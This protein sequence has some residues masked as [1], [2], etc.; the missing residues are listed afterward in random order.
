MGLLLDSGQRP[1]RLG[2]LGPVWAGGALP[3]RAPR[4][5][6]TPRQL[7]CDW[8]PR[9]RRTGRR[10]GMLAA[11]SALASTIVLARSATPAPLAPAEGTSALEAALGTQAFGMRY[12]GVRDGDSWAALSLRTVTTGRRAGRSRGPSR[13]SNTGTCSAGGRRRLPAGPP[14]RGLLQG[15]GAD[16]LGRRQP[17]GPL[18]GGRRLPS[19]A[20]HAADAARGA[21]AAP[22]APRRGLERRPFGLQPRRGPARRALP[23]PEGGG[24]GAAVDL[25][26][27]PRPMVQRR[28]CRAVDGR[29]RLLQGPRARGHPLAR[30]PRE[31]G[32]PPPLV[33][34]RQRPPV[35]LALLRTNAH[36]ALPV[37]REELHPPA[38]RHAPP[39][40]PRRRP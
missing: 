38:T 14:V 28:P 35:H 34:P 30:P 24:R 23:P 19:R 37:L 7:A 39:S 36:P 9:P 27:G 8:V 26:H 12:G 18:F 21:E 10:F 29:L 32:P 2:G 13:T 5:T 40:P 20:G 17:R 33:P 22:G 31:E 4:T 3:P 6:P 25:L 16:S 11:S 15:G 1:A